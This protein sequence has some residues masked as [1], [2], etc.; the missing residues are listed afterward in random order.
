[1]VPF[2]QLHPLHK[3]RTADLPK[4]LVESWFHCLMDQ[5]KQGQIGADGQ[6]LKEAGQHG[7]DPIHWS[8]H[9]A[10]LPGVDHATTISGELA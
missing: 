2:Q 7:I 9:Q 1:M 3:S 8:R 6:R 4:V 10:V 5:M